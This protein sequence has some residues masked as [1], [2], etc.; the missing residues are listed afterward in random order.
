MIHEEMVLRE[1]IAQLKQEMSEENLELIPNY[2]QRVEVLKEL[3]FV[4]PVNVTVSLKG[5]VACEVSPDRNYLE[6]LHRSTM[7][8][9]CCYRS[10]PRTRSC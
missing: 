7:S 5:R 4:D 2:E 8:L 6:R 10:I 1:Q 9:G 3:K